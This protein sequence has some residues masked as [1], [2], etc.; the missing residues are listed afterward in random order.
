MLSIPQSS[1]KRGRAADG[2]DRRQP[3][4][5]KRKAMRKRTALACE[6]CRVRK[7]RCDGAIPACGGCAKRLSECVYSA[8]IETR[9]W[10]NSMI[11]SLRTHLQELE[12][13]ELPSQGPERTSAPSAEY[14]ANSSF[15]GI[16]AAANVLT[17]TTSTTNHAPLQA[18]PVSGQQEPSRSGYLDPC[19]FEKMMEPLIDAK[20]DGST[21]GAP[22][23][24]TR[25][26]AV[27]PAAQVIIC[28]CERSL[29]GLRWNL[30]LRRISDALVAA[31]FSRFHRIYPILHQHTFRRQYERLWASDTGATAATVECSG[32]CKQ[33]SRGKLFPATLHAVFAMA[34]VALE[35][36]AP[37]ENV[38]QAEA[39]YATAAQE[40]DFL[41]MPDEEVGIELVQLG[42]LMG[43]YLQ[44]TEKFSKCWNITGLT[45][46][47]AKNM[48]LD[49]SIGEARKRGLFG[50]RPTQLD[51]E[52]RS[53]VWHGCIILEKEVAMSF[54]RAPMVAANTKSKL[55]EAIDD[56]RLSDEAA[57]W[58][59]QPS[60]LPSLLESYI[61][62][63][64]L[65]DILGHVLCRDE[66]QESRS[67]RNSTGKPSPAT[68]YIRAILDMDTM[69]MEW[70]DS[71]PRYLKHHENITEF[72]QHVVTEDGLAFPCEDLL[73]QAERLYIRFLHVRLLLLRPALERLFEK[74]RANPLSKTKRATEAK[75][76]DVLLFSIAAQCIICAQSLVAFLNTQIQSQKLL[77]WWYDVSYLHSSASTL[78]MGLLCTFNDGSVSQKS[79]SASWELGLQCL[80]RYTGASIIAKK[81]FSLLQES[82]KFLLPNT[83]N[84]DLVINSSVSVAD[85]ADSV[86]PANHKP[87]DKC[88]KPSAYHDCHQPQMIR[89]SEISSRDVSGH[90]Q[91]RPNRWEEL[92]IDIWT[93]N[94]GGTF[95]WP[96]IPYPSQLETLPLNLNFPE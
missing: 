44:S 95:H 14:P 11:Q 31:Y 43:F 40:V 9:A 27:S 46:R 52:M 45:I 60:G 71:L 78:L 62:T 18:H 2:G 35:P 15:N 17:L 93:G 54:G 22:V 66:L 92:D 42:L 67:A 41:N 12:A 26:R 23:W 91:G 36:G 63:I 89:D 8:E 65:Y 81:S 59:Y 76:E 79:I 47:M 94:S 74:Q 1:A 86:W 49:L 51:C 20:S 30:P 32:L 50:C 3:T 38:S 61:E 68:L 21:T 19:S 24:P 53:R 48:G 80:S 85:I 34:T 57:K 37:S 10:H 16:A 28:T 4:P 72:S 33:R 39:F 58:N 55:P 88:P 87:K 70:W 73:A 6:E 56:D 29:E 77:A 96:F 7:R 90:F 82:A 83:C 64:K 5:C 75:L 84:D 13:A 69:I 25:P